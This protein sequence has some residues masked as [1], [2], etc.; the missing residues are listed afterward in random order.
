MPRELASR[1]S[2]GGKEGDTNNGSYIKTVFAD[3]VYA[4]APLE[5][6]GLD[7][8]LDELETGIEEIES[9]LDAEI[10]HLQLVI[11]ILNF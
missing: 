8:R 7:A 1:R 5:T 2:V 11:D 4:W 3:G 9:E 10:D 6:E